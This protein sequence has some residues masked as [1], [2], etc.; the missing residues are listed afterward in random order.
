MLL[1]PV[2]RMVWG[3]RKIKLNFYFHS[4]IFDILFEVVTKVMIASLT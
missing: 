4:R 1:I 3:I 2:E